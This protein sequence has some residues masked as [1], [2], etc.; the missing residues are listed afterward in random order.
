MDVMTMQRRGLPARR[1]AFW[2][3][4]G[5]ALLVSHDAVFLA[6]LGP[7]ESLA[8]TLRHAT[9]EYWGTASLAILVSGLV[10]A[11]A[12]AL[13]LQ[14]LH[15]RASELGARLAG[16]ER[17]GYLRRVALAWPALFAVVAVGFLI[18]ENVEHAAGHGHL[19]GAGALFGP[20]YPLAIPV[21]ALITLVGALLGA[22]VARAER[23]LV[24][25]IDR[26]LRPMLRPPRHLMRPPIRVES[27]P[28]R[29]LAG[30]RAG[31]A[32][33]SPLASFI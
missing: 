33:P 9:H 6:Q 26:A 16:A 25:A 21:I 15:R 31:R 4:A 19:P 11:L 29:A 3:L 17:H 30:T 5:V 14:R 10:V 23:A 32:P 20:E 22:A 8:Q 7:G 24:T 13:R 28:Q 27:R 12:V 2:A 1:I 18:Q